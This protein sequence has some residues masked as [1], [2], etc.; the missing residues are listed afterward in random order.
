MQQIAGANM[1]THV[2]D[3]FASDCHKLAA[4]RLDNTHVR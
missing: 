3:N 2:L 4:L 1:F